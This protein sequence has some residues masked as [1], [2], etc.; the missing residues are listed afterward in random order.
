M[1]FFRCSVCDYIYRIETENNNNEESFDN[2]PL[3]WRCPDCGSHKSCFE[4]IEE[5]KKE[6]KNE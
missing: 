2:L 5:N 4:L 1:K 3:D 6:K